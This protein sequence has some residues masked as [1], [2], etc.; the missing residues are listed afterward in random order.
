MHSEREREREKESRNDALQSSVNNDSSIIE[1]RKTW[2][3]GYTRE[4]E[5]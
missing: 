2:M 4:K 3:S 5:K 1:L